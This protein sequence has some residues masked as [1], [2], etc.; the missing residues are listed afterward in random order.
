MLMIGAVQNGLTSGSLK[1]FTDSFGGE[2]IFHA[3]VSAYSLKAGGMASEAAKNGGAK[4]EG[5][6][7]IYLGTTSFKGRRIIEP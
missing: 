3:Y 7:K 2:E 5:V 6:Q 1:A 4:V